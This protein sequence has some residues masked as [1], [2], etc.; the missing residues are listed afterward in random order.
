MCCIGLM[1]PKPSRISPFVWKERSSCLYVNGT[2]YFNS[3]IIFFVLITSKSYQ[4][5]YLVMGIAFP[6]WSQS[7]NV[8]GLFGFHWHCCVSIRNYH[9]R[10]FCLEY[11][12]SCCITKDKTGSLRLAITYVKTLPSHYLFTIFQVVEVFRINK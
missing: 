9:L 12:F 2:H 3:K 4:L 10:S 6:F 7:L 5:S 1:F 8:R 11:N